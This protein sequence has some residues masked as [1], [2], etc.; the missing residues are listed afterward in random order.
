VLFFQR[1]ALP[2]LLFVVGR[3]YKEAYLGAGVVGKQ[4]GNLHRLGL[5]AQKGELLWS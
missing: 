1:G 2:L 4:K 5:K 3:V